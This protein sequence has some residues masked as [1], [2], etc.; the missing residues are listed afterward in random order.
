M[1]LDGAGK[2]DVVNEVV[3]VLKAGNLGGKSVSTL[4]GRQAVLLA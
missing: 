4:E 3:G 2:S 1:G